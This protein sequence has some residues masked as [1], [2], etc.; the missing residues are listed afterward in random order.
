MWK[1][2]FNICQAMI[3]GSLLRKRIMGTETV[4]QRIKLLPATV[5]SYM[6]AG[7]PVPAAPLLIQLHTDGLEKATEGSTRV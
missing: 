7:P 4:A 5:A 2:L 3:S 1:R 6:G